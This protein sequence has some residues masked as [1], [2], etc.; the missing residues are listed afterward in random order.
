MRIANVDGRLSI[1]LSTG[2]VDVERASAGQFGSDPQSIYDRWGEFREWALGAQASEVQP[3]GGQVLGSPAPRP[4][5]VFAIGLNYR[6]HADESGFDRPAE[7]PPVFTKFSSSITGPVGVV[8][9]PERGNVDW[10][11]ELTAVIGKPARNVAEH[12]GW[13]YVAGL[14][15]G[16]DISERSL[17]MASPAPQFSLAKSLPGFSPMGPDLVTVDEFDNPDDLALSCEINGE[18]VQDGRTVDLIFSVPRLIEYL[19]AIL[20]LFPGDVIFTGTPSGVGMGRS[21]QRWLQDGDELVSRIEGIGEIRQTF[22]GEH[23]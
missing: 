15:I 10:E 9:L 4:R 17:Q 2:F 7:H 6:E 16:Q 12:D 14:T 19:S 5:Q 21:P 22:V 18:T 3:R 13:S 8:E 20:P 23:R 1:A 11:V